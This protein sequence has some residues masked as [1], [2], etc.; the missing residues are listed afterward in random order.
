MRRRFAV[1]P[2]FGLTYILAA[3]SVAAQPLSNPLTSE[4]V[5]CNEA[6]LAGLLDRLSVDAIHHQTTEQ[7]QTWAVLSRI[8]LVTYSNRFGFF[9][10]LAVAGW[11]APGDDTAEGTVRGESF[12]AFDLNPSIRTTLANP[13]R[14]RLAQISL[15]REETSSTLVGSGSPETLAVFLNPTAVPNATSGRLEINNL[16]TAAPSGQA[17]SADTKPGRGLAG[18][19]SPCH[20]E[21][22]DFDRFVFEVL[23]RIFR[24]Q[25]PGNPARGSKVAIFRGEEP[26]TYRVDVYPVGAKGKVALDL[27]LQVDGEGRLQTGSLRILP[28]CAAGAQLG[29][30]SAGIPLDFFLFPPVSGGTGQTR[31]TSDLMTEISF[32]PGTTP[33]P[34]T[35]DF[36]RLLGKTLWNG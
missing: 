2:L 13:A 5:A 14:Q 1:L 12:L 9:E 30:S 3:G 8:L 18:L 4:Q 27:A 22:T 19:T 6:Q 10:G 23:E 32:K 7:S 29:C 11:I 26:L 17:R 34:V 16:Q 15:M 35:A 25:A 33:S 28:G 31:V 20:T 36:I 24:V 21:L